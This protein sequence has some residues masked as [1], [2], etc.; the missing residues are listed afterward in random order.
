MTLPNLCVLYLCCR[1]SRGYWVAF[2]T[3]AAAC[4]TPAAASRA[5]CCAG[6]DCG[7]GIH[8][9]PQRP[10]AV[11]CPVVAGLLRWEEEE[12]GA[13]EAAWAVFG[14]GATQARAWL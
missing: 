2:T 7:L 10:R 8:A 11:M 1:R 13:G 9:V 12:A 4:S 5:V 14:M 3:W 6:Q